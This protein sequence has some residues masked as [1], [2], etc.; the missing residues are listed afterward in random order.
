MIRKI[1]LVNSTSSEVL[2]F[3]FKASPLSIKTPKLTEI[4]ANFFKDYKPDIETTHNI[5]RSNNGNLQEYF[6]VW[7]SYDHK[8]LFCGTQYINDREAHAG[9]NLLKY[10]PY[11]QD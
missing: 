10:E 11:E 1:D 9:I 6:P 4:L 2:E 3:V 5:K 8:T 7:S